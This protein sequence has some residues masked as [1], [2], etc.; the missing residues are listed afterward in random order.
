MNS[1][2]ASSMSR[3]GVPASGPKL[4]HQAMRCTVVERPAQVHLG[5]RHATRGIL[6]P[7][8]ASFL[9][10]D[11]GHMPQ[12]RHLGNL[13]ANPPLSESYRTPSF[14]TSALAQRRA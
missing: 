8:N 6:P 1:A 4:L 5:V 14:T 12:R 7:G 10:D 2:D 3:S 13:L 11:D 9:E